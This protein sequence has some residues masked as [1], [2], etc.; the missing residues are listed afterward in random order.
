MK[1]KI[2]TTIYILF[3]IVIQSCQKDATI[4][5][6]PAESKLVVGAFL[7]PTDS[8]TQLSLS[9]SHPLYDNPNTTTDFIPVTNATVLISD[10]NFSYNLL[11]NEKMKRYII[12]SFKIKIRE[13]KQYSLLITTPEGKS[14]TSETTI[15]AYTPFTYTTAYTGSN[16]VYNLKGSWF[17]R[18]NSYFKFEVR[19]TSFFIYTGHD[20]NTGDFA[21]TIKTWNGTSQ[22]YDTPTDKIFNT[23]ADFVYNI[24]KNDTAFVSLSSV[25]K[26]YFD[27]FKRLEIASTYDPPFSEPAQMY[28]NINGGYGVFA[29]L[30]LYRIRIFP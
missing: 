25:S 3:T 17:G 15:P 24:K 20:K 30:N 23:N 2:I 14:V 27:Y 18:T 19:Y 1:R 12:D 9:M 5:L 7:S 13:G 29:G 10:G 8:L 28:T 22:L 6:P 4:K 16:D 11:Y 26:E 21:D